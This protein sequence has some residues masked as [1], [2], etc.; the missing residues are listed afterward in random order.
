MESTPTLISN[1]NIL[2][3]K[4]ISANGRRAPTQPSRLPHNHSSSVQI[5]GVN[6]KIHLFLAVNKADKVL[7]SPRL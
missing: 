4:L 6:C 3:L 7:H 5:S 2:N 1:Q